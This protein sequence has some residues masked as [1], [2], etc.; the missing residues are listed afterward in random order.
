MNFEEVCVVCVFCMGCCDIV[1][2]FEIGYNYIDYVIFEKVEVVIVVG[3][4]YVYILEYEIYVDYVVEGGYVML[5]DL[6]VN[7]DWEVV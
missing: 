7:G 5:V 2:V 3:D 4:I 6:C 1:F